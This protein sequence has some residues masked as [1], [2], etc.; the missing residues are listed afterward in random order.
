MSANQHRCIY[1]DV[2]SLSLAGCLFLRKQC[3]ITL[4]S[5]TSTRLKFNVCFGMI[6]Q[7][8][9]TISEVSKTLVPVDQ[10]YFP[11]LRLGKYILSRGTRIL[12]TPSMVYFNCILRNI[13]RPGKHQNMKHILVKTSN[14]TFYIP[15]YNRV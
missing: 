1:C 9:Y 2:T 14:R 7:L 5:C 15:E 3:H 10:T 8:K 11:R 13:F 12:L 4:F 6:K